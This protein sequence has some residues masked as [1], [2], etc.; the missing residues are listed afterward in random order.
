MPTR[1]F[2]FSL[3]CLFFSCGSSPEEVAEA[4]AKYQDIDISTID[5]SDFLLA[6]SA[7]GGAY[8]FG[9]PFVFVD[10]A[11][12]IVIPV[13]AYQRTFT[14]PLFYGSILASRFSTPPPLPH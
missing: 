2:L 13:R 12:Q 11:G 4:T 8:A 3:L 9:E 10:Q 7:T 5:T 14:E 6:S 1:L